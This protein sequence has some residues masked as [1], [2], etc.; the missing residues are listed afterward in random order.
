MKGLL[1]IGVISVAVIGFSG[2][3]KYASEEELAQL[4]KLKQEVASMETN[5]NTLKSEKTKLEREIAEKNAKLEQC[6]KDKAET[7]ANLEKLPK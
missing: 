3:T 7:K 1:T 5:V 2:C 4:G 6:A